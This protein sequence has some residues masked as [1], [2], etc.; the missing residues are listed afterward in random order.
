MFRTSAKLAVLLLA[1]SPILSSGLLPVA[2]PDTPLKHVK[3]INAMSNTVYN[4]RQNK[5]RE[6]G[7]R[8][9]A[10]EAT[11]EEEPSRREQFRRR[12]MA[13]ALFSTY[14]TVMGAKCA[15]PSVLSQLTAPKIGL[16]FDGWASR[17]QTLMAQQL[18]LATFAVALGKLLLGPLIDKF[19]GVLALQA[20]LSTLMVMLAIIASANNFITFAVAWMIVDFVFSSCWAGCMNAVHQSF[21]ENEWAKRIGMIAAAARTG[22]AS[23]FFMFAYVLQWSNKHLPPDGQPWRL[24]FGA[25]AALQIIP[26]A[27]LAHFGRMAPDITGPAV[28]KESEQAAHLPQPKGTIQ[29]SLVTLR[30]EAMTPEFWFHLISRS[31]LMVFGS[32]LLFVPTLMSQVYGL[33]NSQAAQVASALA[34]GCLTSVTSCSQLYATLPKRRKI[35]LSTAFMG[36]ATLCSLAQLS[37]MTGT[38]SLSPGLSTL[39]MFF[40]GFAFAVPFYIPPS[41]FA[42]ARGGKESSATISDVFDIFGFGL[43]AVFNGYVASIRHSSA[44]AWIPAFQILTGCSITSMIS[45]GLAIFFE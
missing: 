23:A 11:M 29:S 22:N 7:S 24:V 18:T 1:S 42:L 33:S 44:A 8:R 21:P 12:G 4:H 28:N 32:F 35:V 31:A 30:R 43:L 38:V 15:L 3:R 9:D 36:T 10:T 37:H 41:M 20:C 17:P 39:T 19:G 14:F 16:S 40:W 26:I 5:V 25:S 2:S 13:A 6:W 27:L 34:L 45:L